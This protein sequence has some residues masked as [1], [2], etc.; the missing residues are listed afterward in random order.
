MK[1]L[2]I[3]NFSRLFKIR[4]Q[5]LRGLVSVFYVAKNRFHVIKCA[6]KN[7]ALDGKI[8]IFTV[9]RKRMKKTLSD[10]FL[11]LVYKIHGK[12]RLKGNATHLFIVNFFI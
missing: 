9:I 2:L 1:F 11:S 7:Q 4:K 10:L 5:V 6:M 3:N 8:H 12:P